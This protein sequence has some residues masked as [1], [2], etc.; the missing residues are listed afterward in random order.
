MIPLVLHIPHASNRIPSSYRRHILLDDDALHDELL[1][2]TDAFTDHFARL[3]GREY[4]QRVKLDVSRLLCDVERFRADEI[5]PM[6]RVG[7]GAVY[8]ATSHGEPL[9]HH[10]KRRR[11]HI[12]RRYYDPHH[13]RL[14]AAVDA[15]VS[16]QGSCLIVDMHSFPSRPLPYE[17]DQSEFRPEICIGFNTF[18]GR[19]LADGAWQRACEAAGFADAE[20]NRPFAGSIVP[21]K[22]T[23]YGGVLSAMIEVRRDLYMD[24]ATGEKLAA[25]PKVARKVRRLVRALATLAEDFL[26]H[27]RWLLQP[28]RHRTLPTFPD[29]FAPL[30]HTIMQ[31]LGPEKSHEILTSAAAAN[32][33]R[34]HIQRLVDDWDAARRTRADARPADAATF[35]ELDAARAEWLLSDIWD[36]YLGEEGTGEG[37]EVASY[38]WDGEGFRTSAASSF[39]ARVEEWN[40]LYFYLDEVQSRG[41]YLSLEQ[42]MGFIDQLY[43]TQPVPED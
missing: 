23:G 13:A 30:L 2:M 36:E 35:T 12:L 25:F 42:P 32:T 43:E 17:Q 6:A 11:E 16:E 41:P 7:M 4:V 21:A 38:S 37:I 34:S 3:R 5:E 24:E 14:T 27:E 31:I 26:K 8:I 20:A 15:A 39:S 40:G 18:D 19:F 33:T 9:R 1:A 28:T 10:D 29:R 22:H